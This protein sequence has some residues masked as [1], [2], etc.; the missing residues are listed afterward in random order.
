[1]KTINNT[2]KIFLRILAAMLFLSVSPDIFS[3]EYIRGADHYLYCDTSIVRTKGK[4]TVLTYYH[5]HNKS[6]FML[7]VSGTNPV[8]ALFIE[9]VYVND[10]ELYD[11][12]VFFCGYKDDGGVKKGVYGLFLISTLPSSTLSYVVVDTCTELK[13]LEYYIY[14]D[15][16]YEEIHLAMIG[17][18]G[19]LNNVLI[20]ALPGGTMPTPPFP[21]YPFCGYS[22]YFSNND[23][24]FFDDVAV[25]EN[26]VVVSTRSKISGLPVI[27]FWQFEKQTASLSS[28]LYMPIHHLRMGSPVADSQ[29]FLEHAENDNYAAVFKEQGYSR[30]VMLQLTAPQ[31]VI[32][33]VEIWGDEA[34]TVIPIDIKY[35]KGRKDFD[36]LARYIYYRGD[37]D[38]QF[39]PMQIYHVT[40]T[41]LNQTLPLGLGTNYP[42]NHVWSIDPVEPYHFVASGGFGRAIRLFKYHYYQWE[43]CPE[44]FLYRY[45]IG[46]PYIYVEK[47]NITELTWY[48]K[49]VEQI[50]VN[51]LTRDFPFICPK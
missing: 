18:T 43:N 13:K 8:P 23:N 32:N 36:I 4:D 5:N 26:Y 37:Y 25:T 2:K 20:H 45:D 24:E 11:N 35:L 47:D 44:S 46:N 16:L 48:D 39:L 40:Q 33:S 28:F 41:V 6:V 50:V 10:F 22:V 31:N 9:P 19:K 51:K 1:M 27:D 42:E 29:V 14:H 7:M 34:Q 15:I 17:T 12:V 21:A 38:R 30:M 49:V 3:Q